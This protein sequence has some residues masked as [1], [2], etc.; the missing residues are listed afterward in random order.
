M[1]NDIIKPSS[2][3]TFLK[4]CGVLFAAITGV[5]VIAEVVQAKEPAFVRIPGCSA[6]YIPTNK[7]IEGKL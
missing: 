5:D 3:R 1:N 7:I 6:H 4:Q 2:R